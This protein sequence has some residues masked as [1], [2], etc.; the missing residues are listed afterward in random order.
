MASG[1]AGGPGRQTEFTSIHLTLSQ[2]DPVER[3]SC[4][5]FVSLPLLSV[6]I[7]VEQ[8]HVGSEHLCGASTF[9][10]CRERTIFVDPFR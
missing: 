2:F 5:P 9:A 10:E 4:A 3:K 6:C 8:A 7:L 1:A